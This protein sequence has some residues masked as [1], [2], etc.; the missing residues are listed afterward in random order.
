MSVA[1]PKGEIM[2]TIPTLGPDTLDSIAGP[3]DVPIA[4]LGE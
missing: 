1:S 4:P 2:K 3:I